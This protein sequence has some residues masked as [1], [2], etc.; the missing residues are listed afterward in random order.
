VV[1][2][3]PIGSALI[4][5]GAVLDAVGIHLTPLLLC[6]LSNKRVKRREKE[7]GGGEENKRGKVAIFLLPTGGSCAD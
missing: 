6:I 2:F 7:G 4:E 1:L 3:S 5:G